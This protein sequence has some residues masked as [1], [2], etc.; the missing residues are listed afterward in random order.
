MI[1]VIF[2]FLSL[3]VG[4]T[5]VVLLTVWSLYL[6]LHIGMR[7]WSVRSVRR[8]IRSRMNRFLR[9]FKK[10]WNDLLMNEC[11]PRCKQFDNVYV[12]EGAYICCACQFSW[13]PDSRGGFVCPTHNVELKATPVWNRHRIQLYCP[14]C[15]SYYHVPKELKMSSAGIQKKAFLLE[16]DL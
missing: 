7:P 3:I 5:S 15:K 2:V 12:L 10:T 13:T 4:F 11:C 8:S 9:W 1:P 6:E 14:V 16:E